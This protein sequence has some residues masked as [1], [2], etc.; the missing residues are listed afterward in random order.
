[1]KALRGNTLRV[2]P[3][4]A[5]SALFLILSPF[6]TWITIVSVVVYQGVVVFGAAAQSDLLMVSSDQLGT[7]ISSSALAG[8]L[9]SV[10]LLLVGGTLM[11]KSA[12]VGVPVS[13]LGLLAYLLPAYPMFGGQS[14]G[15]EQTFISPGVGFFVA[16]TG[17]F[18]GSLSLFTKSEPAASLL[19]TL[20]TREGLSKAGVFVGTIGLSLD[21]L[22]HTALGQLA[23]F[24][25]LTPVEQALHLGLLAGV[26]SLLAVVAAGNRVNAG[27]YLFPLSAATLLLLGADAAYSFSTGN[28]HDFL[29][30][31][32]TETVLHL[33]VYYGVSTVLISNFLRPK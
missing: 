2:N 13:A 29:G 32:L 6:M 27:R 23:D 16:G 11:L 4:R 7:N 26:A 3:L 33:A 31:N 19:R 22:N 25:G 5:A 9:S 12:K 17:V 1:M 24:I 21:I 10:A 28:L 14:S 20:K 15:L 18:L 8:A 30:H